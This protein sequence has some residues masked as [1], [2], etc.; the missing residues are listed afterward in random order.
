MFYPTEIKITV[1]VAYNHLCESPQTKCAMG[2]RYKL[3]DCIEYK[4]EKDQV[5]GFEES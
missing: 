1:I 2:A 4:S 3:Y 5:L